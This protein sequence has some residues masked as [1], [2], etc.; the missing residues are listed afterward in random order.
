[1]PTYFP[2]ILSIYHSYIFFSPLEHFIFLDFYNEESKTEFPPFH[3]HLIS[4]KHA[5][6][7]TLYARTYI[8]IPTHLCELPYSKRDLNPAQTTWIFKY[9]SLILW[10]LTQICTFAFFILYMSLKLHL[11]SI[12]ST[13]NVIL[14]PRHH[15]KQKTSLLTKK[16]LRAKWNPKISI[17]N[18]LDLHHWITIAFPAIHIKIYFCGTYK[19]SKYWIFFLTFPSNYIHILRI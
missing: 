17:N 16:Y 12:N 5:S 19:I 9:L 10:I 14:S 1:M 6:S 2:F 18:P 11:K 8:Y 15:K 4:A 3:T 13:S 7:L